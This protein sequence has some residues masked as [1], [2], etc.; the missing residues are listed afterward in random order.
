[1][2]V[3][4]ALTATGL[5]VLGLLALPA[6]APAADGEGLYGRTTD[7]VVTIFAF[8]VLIFFVVFVVGMSLLQGRLDSRKQRAREEIE[9]AR[10]PQP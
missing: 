1:M 5:S 8:G 3:R 6:L 2:N 4:R 9:R 10:P 7:L